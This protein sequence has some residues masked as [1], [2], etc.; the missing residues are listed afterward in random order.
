MC[1]LMIPGY[2]SSEENPTDLNKKERAKI[3]YVLKLETEKEIRTLL[4]QPVALL[5]EKI[6]KD[7]EKEKQIEIKRSSMVKTDR[8]LTEL[9]TGIPNQ[10]KISCGHKIVRVVIKL[11]ATTSRASIW[12]SWEIRKLETPALTLTL[13]YDDPDVAPSEITCQGY[14]Y[15]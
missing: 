12:N 6:L 14:K 4:S 9:L 3:N 1:C 5:T 10:T 2:G 7:I 13:F 11:T 8:C 15:H